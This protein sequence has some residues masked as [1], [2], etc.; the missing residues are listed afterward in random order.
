E[1]I[2]AAR[3]ALADHTPL[4]R[5]AGAGALQVFGAPERFKAV[6][7]IV[8][9][10]ATATAGIL[11]AERTQNELVVK[12]LAKRAAAG[13]T[14]DERRRAIATLGRGDSVDAL[15]ALGANAKDPAVAYEVA[16]ALS[17]SPSPGALAVVEKLALDPKT[18]G[19]GVRAYV[20]RRSAFGES[21][22]AVEDVIDALRGSK[23]GAARA[24]G[25]FA[26]IVRGSGDVDAALA[27]R[28]PR[29]RRA[30][31]LALQ[32]ERSAGDR[33][34]LVERAAKE[35]DEGVKALSMIALLDR[36]ARL[37]VP[38]TVLDDH[39]RSA[40]ADAPLAV[41]ARAA[42]K[43]EDADD[44][45]TQ[46]LRSPEAVVRAHAARGLAESK[47][48]DA[49]GILANAYAREV[50]PDARRAIVVALASAAPADAEIRTNTLKLAA[51]CDPDGEARLDASRALAGL[52]VLAAPAVTQ[53]AWLAITTGDGSKP[54]PGMLGSVVRSDGLALPVVFDDDGF[55]LVPG[56]PPGEARLVLAPRFVPDED[57]AKR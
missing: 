14:L 52:P 41:W 30:V 54:P 2:A 7:A 35:T 22:Q 51:F 19:L 10:D 31:A 9:D 8:D 45:V 24:L 56:M 6:A 27:D 43:T 55:A 3:E 34:K 29:V 16:R 20:V 39:A 50:D 40:G 53:I 15:R 21:S 5:I 23:D 4:V 18:S 32:G 46:L 36:D 44:V 57:A 28:D 17:T 13:G 37:A 33:H 26:T 47:A 12:A 48:P 25:T 49:V 42:R 1:S 38:T 11:F